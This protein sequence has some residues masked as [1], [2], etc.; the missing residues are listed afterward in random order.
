MK[1]ETFETQISQKQK[2]AKRLR[3]DVNTTNQNN[4]SRP[5]PNIYC[6]VIACHKSSTIDSMQST[7]HGI[8]DAILRIFTKFVIFECRVHEQRQFGTRRM[9][10]LK[11]V[12]ASRGLQQS[13][14]A[15][16]FCSHNWH[17]YN[18]YSE[19]QTALQATCRCAL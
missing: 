5:Q 6:T 2:G 3:P 15:I 12:I 14:R 8:H 7:R 9:Q 11:L 19:T 13:F 10:S 17:N 16:M 4:S 1:A 18:L